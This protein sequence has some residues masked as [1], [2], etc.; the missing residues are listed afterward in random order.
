MPEL[1]DSCAT[2]SFSTHIPEHL[3]KD[4]SLTDEGSINSTTVREDAYPSTSLPEVEW[5]PLGGV[6][7]RLT[8]AGNHAHYD[9]EV[10]SWP[11]LFEPMMAKQKMHDM[12]DMRDRPYKIGDRML[13]REFDPRTGKYTGREGV[14][15]ITYI[16]NNETP[17]AMSSSVLARD[18]AILSVTC[19]ELGTACDRNA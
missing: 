13:L 10:K 16:T 3:R 4:Q 12:R 1:I 7:P 18:F 2:T 6:P 15:L 8:P 11:W 19:H 5:H 17:C 14:A 9:Y